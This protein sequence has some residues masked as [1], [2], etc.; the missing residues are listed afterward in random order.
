MATDVL[1]V[2]G[3]MR[4]GKDNETGSLTGTPPNLTAS[5]N[6]NDWVWASFGMS[7]CSIT[8]P[9]TSLKITYTTRI[10]NPNTETA[11]LCFV[12]NLTCPEGVVS[13][14]LLW[15]Y[16]KVSTQTG[17]TST[18]TLHSYIWS[19]NPYTGNPWTATDINALYFGVG[20]WG[21]NGSS[22]VNVWKL[23]QFSVEITYVPVTI[24]TFTITTLPAT[25]VWATGATIHGLFKWK[26]GKRFYVALGFQYS[27]NS[28]FRGCVGTPSWEKNDEDGDPVITNIQW[29]YTLG[30][31]DGHIA[32]MY[33]MQMTISG[34]MPDRTYYYRACMHVH[35]TDGTLI[36]MLEAGSNFFGSALSFGGPVS[37]SGQGWEYVTAKKA[38]DDVSKLAAG[39]Y[40]MDKSGNF[41]YESA[42]HRKA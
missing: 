24:T 18:F 17:N 33:P 6:N 22:P 27:T 21:G 10:I 38:E 34:L 13:Q 41:M 2:T 3:A 40:Y 12:D 39:R 32:S 35:N 28:N 11:S 31:P 20:F 14:Y 25:E 7:N 5:P 4:W 8:E 15:G 23:N 1:S 9:I 37:I 19:V 30:Q 42:Q 16:F 36:P 26:E 29:L